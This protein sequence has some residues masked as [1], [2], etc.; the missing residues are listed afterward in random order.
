MR[1]RTFEKSRPVFFKALSTRIWVETYRIGCVDTGLT[2]L[3]ISDAATSE[4]LRRP[5]KRH[6]GEQR[7]ERMHQHVRN[8]SKTWSTTMSA[9]S[10]T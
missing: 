2:F 10:I 6:R 8:K 9:P 1:H 4:H 5:K 3:S 7:R